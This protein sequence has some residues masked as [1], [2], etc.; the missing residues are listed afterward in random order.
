MFSFVV[1]QFCEV[2]T[3]YWRILEWK[4]STFYFQSGSGKYC[5]SSRVN[6]K[7]IIITYLIHKSALFK[8]LCN[9]KIG[10]QIIMA[11]THSQASFINLHACIMH[12][13]SQISVVIFCIRP[14]WRKYLDQCKALG[15]GV[16]YSE[17]EL[18]SENWNSSWNV[19][20]SCHISK[21]LKH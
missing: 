20:V 14:P 21:H 6:Y 5:T 17:G 1:Q 3:R 12:F 13:L 10:L 15:P 16:K 19:S 8:T 9:N 4:M 7:I 11:S 2:I 18:W